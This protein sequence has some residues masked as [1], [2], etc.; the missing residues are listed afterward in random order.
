MDLTR[1]PTAV[2]K[3]NNQSKGAF[4][5]IELLVVI[6]IIAI[7]ASMLLPALGKA[8]AKAQ[9]TKCTGNTKQ[10]MLATIM[11]IGDADDKTPH[12][13][14]DFQAYPGWLMQPQNNGKFGTDS[15]MVTGV[16]W[17]YLTEKKVFACPSDYKERQP[18]HLDFT[19]RNQTNT[20]YLMNGALCAYRI[21]AQVYKQNQD[22]PDD[23]IL[24]QAKHDS[25]GDYNDASSSPTEGIFQAHNGGTTI[26]S[27][28]GHCEF[29]KY[30]RFAELAVQTFKNRVWCNP[31]TGNGRP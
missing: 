30:R 2:M 29:M 27:I 26:G 24:W 21:Q 1:E 20:S 12:P 9:Q 8:K 13:N 6:A 16:L 31:M 3:R 18:T 10:L 5:L 7:L 17:K 15:N 23:V 25:P 11:Y 28:G 4:T 14:W 22:S 19:S